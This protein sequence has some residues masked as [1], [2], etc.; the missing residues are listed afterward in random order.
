MVNP[1]TSGSEG[2]RRVRWSVSTIPALVLVA[3]RVA[4]GERRPV[5]QEAEQRHLLGA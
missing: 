1:G 5:G 2:G 4:H 3:A